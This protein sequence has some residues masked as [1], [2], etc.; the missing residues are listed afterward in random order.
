ME[1]SE[2]DEFLSIQ[3]EYNPAIPNEYEKIVKEKREKIKEERKR[4]RSPSPKKSGF[5]RRRHS[6]DE[7][8]SFRPVVGSNRIGA[9]IAPPKSLQ[10]SSPVIDLPNIAPSYGSNVAAKIMAK[11]GFKDG[12]G[13]GKQEQGIS[14]ALIVEKTS[15]RGGRIINEKEMQPVAVPQPT[16]PQVQE[17]EYTGEPSITEIMKNPSKV[18]LL[19]NMVG[20][21]EVDDELEP[22]VKDECT[23]KYGEVSTVHITEMPNRVPEET[24]RI[25]VEFRKIEHAIK[26]LVDLSGRFF[27]GRQVRCCFYDLEKYENFIFDA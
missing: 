19:R 10:E 3:D 1:S 7:E 22:E 27:G 14:T 25:F 2:W 21:G 11:Y 20:P 23:T 17:D 18:I 5:G 8:E 26:A 6:S 9:S 12:Q 4:H 16:T 24:V 13:L 15:K